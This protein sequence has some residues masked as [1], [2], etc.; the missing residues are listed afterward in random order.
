MQENSYEIAACQNL[1]S[2]RCVTTLR[3][4][5]RATLSPTPR[6]FASANT[7]ATRRLPHT[8]PNRE[9]ELD[10]DP[11]ALRVR[12]PPIEHPLSTTPRK[13]DEAANASSKHHPGARLRYEPNF[14][15]QDCNHSGGT[16]EGEIRKVPMRHVGGHKLDESL[17]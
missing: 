16:I 12:P 5:Y 4:A 6:S 9:S 3:V 7:I 11:V 13:Q 14:D 17:P 1:I 8:E 2:I 15:V 10:A